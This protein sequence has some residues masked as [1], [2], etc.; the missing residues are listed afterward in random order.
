MPLQPRWPSRY[1]DP[2][3]HGG[4]SLD[5]NWNKHKARR[6]VVSGSDTRSAHDILRAETAE[7]H[8]RLHA[9]A[10]L[11]ALVDGR[12]SRKG[13]E[14]LMCRMYGFYRP[15]DDRICSAEKNQISIP[16]S[17]AFAPR[18]PML[19]GDLSA[20]GFDGCQL[21]DLPRCQNLPEIT[22]PADL[23]G[24]LYVIDGATRGGVLLNACVSRL[25]GTESTVGRTY[26]DWC[27]QSGGAHWR[28]TRQ[29]IDRFGLDKA[30]TT[31]MT[32]AAK[33][34]FLAFESWFAPT[35]HL[36]AAAVA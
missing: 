17:V 4:S 12:L 28:S 33:Q 34:T 6:Q 18:S 14:W 31:R 21:D 27:R 11:S 25:L 8:E 13:Y 20:L 9:D 23:A 2:R 3:I 19:A 5:L 32:L 16:R 15:L 26:W 22:T 35:T 10:T 29:S 30:A 7:I 24:V 1:T 36:N